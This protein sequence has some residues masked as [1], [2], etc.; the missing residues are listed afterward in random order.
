MSTALSHILFV[1]WA[2]LR[3]YCR[4]RNAAMMSEP[5]QID[6]NEVVTAC[7]N[8]IAVGHSSSSLVLLWF[9]KKIVFNFFENPFKFLWKDFWNQKLQRE[10][11]K[12]KKRQHTKGIYIFMIKTF[13]SLEW[14]SFRGFSLSLSYSKSFLLAVCAVVKVYTTVVD[15]V[16]LCVCRL[17]S[18]SL[19]MGLSS[20]LLYI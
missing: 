13:F 8:P 15:W 10:K 2:F 11:G 6:P 12:K 7:K 16:S 18:L 4:V 1:F 20:Q 14:F 9:K 17:V 19:S 3:K 5:K